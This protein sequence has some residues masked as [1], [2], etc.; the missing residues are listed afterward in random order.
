MSIVNLVKL[1]MLKEYGSVLFSVKSELD[2]FCLLLDRKGVKYVVEGRGI[3]QNNKPLFC[4][5]KS[6]DGV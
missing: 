3:G 5:T 6:E 2:L 1:K 4:V